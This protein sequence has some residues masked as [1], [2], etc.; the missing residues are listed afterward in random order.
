[1]PAVPP[2]AYA[3]V[4]AMLQH[5]L[6]GESRPG[7]AR[8]S[9]AA[10]VGA[11]GAG[12]L[13]GSVQRFRASATTLEPFRPEQAS[14]LVTDGPNRFTRNPM[15]LGMAGL[16][17]A[18]G[19]ARGGI[20]PLLPVAAFVTVIDRLQIQPEEAALRSA[21]GAEYAAYCDRVPRWLPTALPRPPRAR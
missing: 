6:A 2:P 1:M 20:L 3:L 8:L 13:V 11:A 10:A 9:A 18:H 19:L 16:L 5:A 4:G 21:F 17:T 7:R 15:Y 14:A 12:C